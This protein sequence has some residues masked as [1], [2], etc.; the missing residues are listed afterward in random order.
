MDSIK[1][2]YEIILYILQFLKPINIRKKYN[3]QLITGAYINV[4]YLIS[5][6]NNSLVDFP[7]FYI[8]TNWMIIQKLVPEFENDYYHS[9]SYSDYIIHTKPFNGDLKKINVKYD[10][11][12]SQLNRYYNEEYIVYFNTIIDKIVNLAH[13]N[14]E[15]FFGEKISHDIIRE[16]HIKNKS[17]NHDHDFFFRFREYHNFIQKESIKNIKNE[18]INI[19]NWYNISNHLNKNIPIRLIF[20]IMITFKNDKFII[21]NNT[22][23]IQISKRIVDSITKDNKLEIESKNNLNELIKLSHMVKNKLKIKDKIYYI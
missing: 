23:E 13:D 16:K 8:K 21:N 9:S 5:L 2:P 19:G 3:F 12:S 1:L 15:L 20:K 18:Y 6:Y 17:F 22:H 11:Y 7:H 14:S 4:P 10:D